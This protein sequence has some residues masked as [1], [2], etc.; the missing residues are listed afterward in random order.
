MLKRLQFGI[1]ISV[2]FIILMMPL[3]STTAASVTI[4]KAAM[5]NTAKPSPSKIADTS[6]SKKG[7]SH[8]LGGSRSRYLPPIK[9]TRSQ[10]PDLMPGQSATQLADGRWL[11]LGGEGPNGPLAI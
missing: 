4:S 10:T 2:C 1:V 5:G 9:S 3:L 7:A 11:L 6:K 8:E